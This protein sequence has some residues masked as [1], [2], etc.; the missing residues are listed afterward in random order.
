MTAGSD[1]APLQGVRVVDAST[2]LL[3]P[4]A[5]MML[6][7]LGADVVKVEPPEGDP[8]RRLGPRRGDTGLPAV[9]VNRGKR[10]LM[11]DLKD[12]AG[13]QKFVALLGTADVLIHN[14]RP[15]VAE[16]LN[17]DDAA[18]ARANP[19]L[20][21]VWLTGFG[22]TGPLAGEPAFDLLLQ[23]RTGLASY[24]GGQGEPQG[25]RT[26]IADKVTATFAV[27]AVLA[28]LL[29]RRETGLG[30]G[31][32]ISMLEAVSYF[33]FPD[34]ALRH[35]IVDEP[36]ESG[37]PPTT[38]LPTT[39]GHVA[40]APV[41]GAQ[42]RAA[43]D[44]VGHPEWW[45]DLV[46]LRTSGNLAAA[47]LHRLATVTKSLTTAECLDLFRTADVP[48]AP[49]L[50]V[51]Q[52]LCDPQVRHLEVYDQLPHPGLG[53]VRFARYPGRRPT[54]TSHRRAPTVG[55]H[56]TE[57]LAE[58]ADDATPGRTPGAPEAAAR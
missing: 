49:V 17:L 6:A 23:A 53:Q 40:I 7:D 2:Y 12:V 3:G 14:W 29:Q 30:A 35:A 42:V 26:Y 22:S 58:L 38:L 27:Q 46:P 19:R 43:L 5:A 45:D 37:L 48:V 24:Q 41:S 54:A 52:H 15:G 44:S 56:T 32:E 18:V 57:I 21:R 51:A 9:L 36:L 25:L 1:S 55:E 4:F 13:H 10:S 16:R 28:A 8:Y 47:L 20:V 11:L 31:L 33:N 50:D 39:D 34:L